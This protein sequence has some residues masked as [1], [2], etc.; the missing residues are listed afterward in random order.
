MRYAGVFGPASKEGTPTA[1][2]VCSNCGAPLAVT[3]SGECSHCNAHVTL[4]EF[5]W[6]LSKIEQDDSYRG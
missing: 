3:Q 5:D 6:V 1:E 4:G 2:P